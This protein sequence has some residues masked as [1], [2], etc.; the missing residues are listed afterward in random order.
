MLSKYWFIFC[1]VPKVSICCLLALSMLTFK[2]FK[3]KHT[4]A[5][6]R[7]Q[8]LSPDLGAIF[9]RLWR[10]N[11]I[12]IVILLGKSR[13]I[14]TPSLFSSIDGQ[15]T[16]EEPAKTFFLTIEPDWPNGSLVYFSPQECVGPVIRIIPSSILTSTRINV[17]YM[18]ASG[19]QSPFFMKRALSMF[20]HHL[21]HQPPTSVK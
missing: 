8:K 9:R 7:P 18:L 14:I 12:T 19:L 10:V 4:K 5:H 3:H 11:A 20:A 2:H 16:I 13:C 15:V 17:T 1:C 21:L 6:W